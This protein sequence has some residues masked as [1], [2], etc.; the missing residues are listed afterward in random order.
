[1]S[2]AQIKKLF[3]DTRSLGEKVHTLETKTVERFDLAGNKV[4]VPE[5]ENKAL[6]KR[7]DQLEKII[8]ERLPG[9]VRQPKITQ[10]LK[11]KSKKKRWFTV[12]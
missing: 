10:F 1:M 12:N 4:A 2:D 7:V 11:A 9:D 5:A 8:E 3:C 6:K